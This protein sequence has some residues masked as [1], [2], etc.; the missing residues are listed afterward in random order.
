M[1]FSIGKVV[2]SSAAELL[3]EHTPQDQLLTPCVTQELAGAQRISAGMCLMPPSHQ[4]RAHVHDDHEIVILVLDGHA[5]TLWGWDLT[6]LTHGPGEFVFV[7][8]GV[9]HVAVN[10]SETAR[11]LAVEHRSD[12]NFNSDVRLLPE[13]DERA[14]DIAVALRRRE[15]MRRSMP[16]S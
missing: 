3:A 7:P 1:I 14:K 16:S 11:V 13:L 6:P 4:S 5:A 8:P 15:A 10:L 12:P 2:R 9:P